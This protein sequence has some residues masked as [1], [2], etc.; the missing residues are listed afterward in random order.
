[1]KLN[2]YLTER[3][4][5]DDKYGPP[6]NKT[7]KKIGVKCYYCSNRQRLLNI[8]D[9]K[10]DGDMSNS[11]NCPLFNDSK[12][13]DTQLVE[14]AIDSIISDYDKGY[15]TK[16]EMGDLIANIYRKRF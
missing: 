5:D 8:N 7:Y 9:C 3:L 1:M 10:V 15:L 16:S 13:P 12:I 2:K 14:I 6:S 11:K 4:T